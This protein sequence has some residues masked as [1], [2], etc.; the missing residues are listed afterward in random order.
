MCIFFFKYDNNDQN[1]A[2]MDV[3]FAN[4]KKRCIFDNKE[5]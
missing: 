4:G 1:M 3:Y 2:V 5:R